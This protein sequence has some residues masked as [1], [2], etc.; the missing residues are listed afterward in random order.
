MSH[1]SLFDFFPLP[2]YLNPPIYGFDISDRT[3]KYSIFSKRSG[4]LL[5][6]SFGKHILP[7]GLIVSGEIKKK[8]ELTKFLSIFRKELKSNSIILALPEEKAFLTKINLPLMKKSKIRQ[9]LELQI[10]EQI[11]L[12]LDEVFF[13]YDCIEDKGHFDVHLVAYP[14][15]VILDYRD[16]F[17]KAGFL[18]LVFEMESNA[19]SRSLISEEDASVQIIIDFGRT[20]VS[21][22]VADNGRVKF[23]STINVGGESL[24]AIMSDKF[25]VNKFEAEQL[26][27]EK[28]RAEFNRFLPVVSKI[29]DEV[30]RVVL[31]WN[32]RLKDYGKK[33]KQ[34]EKIVLSGGDSNLSGLLEYFSHEIQIPAEIGNPWINISSFEKNIPQMDKRESL[35]YATAIGLALRAVKNYD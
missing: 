34:I 25:S 33:R 12:S 2:L 20:R 21:F 27:K 5:L 17:K 31:F 8:E 7:E 14:K 23:S 3:I 13:D 30:H 15:K 29:R 35:I 9:A 18:P 19:L 16:T 10:E 6:D 28:Q 1:K 4:K 22:I 26:K 24:N 11:P 32:K